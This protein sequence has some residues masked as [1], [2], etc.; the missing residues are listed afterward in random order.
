MILG[1][2]PD[3]PL[4]RTPLLDQ[5]KFWLIVLGF[6]GL[7]LITALLGL[8]FSRRKIKAMTASGKMGHPTVCGNCWLGAAIFRHVIYGS[9]VHGHN[10]EVQRN[11]AFAFSQFSYANHF[12]WSDF[13]FANLGYI[14][15]EE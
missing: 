9:Y 13:S 14:G 15:L 5:N 8:F 10:A 12:G 7:I 2:I 11:Q 4:E 1:L 3:M 6:S